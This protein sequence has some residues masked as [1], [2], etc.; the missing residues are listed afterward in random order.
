[1]TRQTKDD[2]RPFTHKKDTA[3]TKQQTTDDGSRWKV[4]DDK[5]PEKVFGAGLK[6]ADAR[7]LVSKLSSSHRCRTAKVVEDA[8]KAKRP[9]PPVVTKP[10]GGFSWQQGEKKVV[11]G[12]TAVGAGAPSTVPRPVTKPP[13]P[14]LAGASAVAAS[15]AAAAQA[16]H[17]AVVAKQKAEDE[18]R[19]RAL[20]LAGQVDEDEIV[21]DI[22]GEA[23]DGGAEIDGLDPTSVPDMPPVLPDTTDTAK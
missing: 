12:Q 15:T 22:M 21:G 7:A 19:Q 6:H 16:R 11:E 13:A 23:D 4:V 20:D 8:G 2:I 18:L 3:P 5:N 1:M 9:A 17:D 10:P 14:L